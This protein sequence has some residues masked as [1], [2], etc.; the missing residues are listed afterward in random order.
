MAK[1]KPNKPNIGINIRIPNPKDLLTSKGLKSK[2]EPQAFPA[3]A[4]P[5]AYIV[6]L[7]FRDKGYLNSSVYFEYISTSN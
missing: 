6:E 2:N 3:S 7:G 5:V 1:S 4:Y